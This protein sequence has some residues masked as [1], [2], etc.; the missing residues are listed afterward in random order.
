FAMVMLAIAASV[1]ILLGVVG[2]YGVVRYMAAQRTSEIGLRMALGAQTADVRRLFL[3]RG[4][5][6]TLTGI[7]VG[8][9]AAM[10]LTR[11]MA[12]LLFGVAPTDPITY[13]GASVGLAAI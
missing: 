6:L 1:A 10:F 13:V 4:L 7:A 11:V 8:I 12:A 9:G 2:I 5:V 3:R